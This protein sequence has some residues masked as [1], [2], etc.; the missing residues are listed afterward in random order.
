MTRIEKIKDYMELCGIKTNNEVKEK[1]A[2]PRSVQYLGQLLNGQKPLSQ[3]EEKL[4]YDSINIA[5]AKRIM[6]HD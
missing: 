3:D 2:Y 6:Y 4:I 5:R 1:G